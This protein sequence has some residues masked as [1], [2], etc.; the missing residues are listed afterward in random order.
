M[1]WGAIDLGNVDRRDLPRLKTWA[2]RHG[3]RIRRERLTAQGRPVWRFGGGVGVVDL[4][5]PVLR[6]VV[7]LDPILEAMDE[8]LREWLLAGIREEGRVGLGGLGAVLVPFEVEE[9]YQVWLDPDS[10]ERFIADAEQRRWLAR[11]GDTV[12]DRLA[13][14]EVAYSE[15]I[16]GR[17]VSGEE[18]WRL[19]AA[20]CEH[21]RDRFIP[22]GRVREYVQWR[23]VREDR[24]DDHFQRLEAAGVDARFDERGRVPVIVR[25]HDRRPHC[26]PRRS[27]RGR[28][29]GVR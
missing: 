14:L 16:Q 21:R 1:D 18:F 3:H 2:A 6:D 13:G 5:D 10:A 27:R 12:R 11:F 25:A 4:N 19:V 8:G 9:G 23:R 22:G 24:L 29:R 26:R 7:G 17:D 20:V 15:A 28:S